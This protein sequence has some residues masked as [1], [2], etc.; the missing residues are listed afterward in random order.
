L[1]ESTSKQ[2]HQ[3]LK[4]QKGGYA[5]GKKQKKMKDDRILKEV[6]ETLASFYSS[7]GFRY[8]NEKRKVEIKLLEEKKRHILLEKEKEWK[9]KSKAL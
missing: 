5:M 9:L 2:F 4:K 3:N 6:E 7:E 8:V 1:S